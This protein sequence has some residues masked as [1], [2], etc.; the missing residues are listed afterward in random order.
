MFSTVTLTAI[1]HIAE[2]GYRH[3][4]LRDIVQYGYNFCFSL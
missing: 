2:S 1:R 4:A 3:V